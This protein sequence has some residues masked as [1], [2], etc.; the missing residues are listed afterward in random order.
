M[1]NFK[2]NQGQIWP[3]LITVKTIRD[4]QNMLG[5]NLLSVTEG[6]LLEQLSQD[7]GL[8][9]NV[10]YVVCKPTADER[11]ITDEVF[12]TLLGGDSVESATK[13]F[14]EAL[15]DFFPSQKRLVMRRALEKMD[16]LQTKIF[17]QALMD[18]ES[19]DLEKKL[20]EVM[21]KRPGSSAL[22]SQGLQG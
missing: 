4:V 7:P 1:A 9:C 13:A 11:K 15:V 20:E 14:L 16:Q 5:I 17:S 12:G 21:Q 8:L 2:D 3:V 10:L 18:L 6:P 22:N 19:P